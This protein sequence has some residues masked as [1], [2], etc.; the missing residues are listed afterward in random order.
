MSPIVSYPAFTLFSQG[1]SSNPMVGIRYKGIRDSLKSHKSR[2][3]RKRRDFID[4]KCRIIGLCTID[5]K[6]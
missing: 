3:M 2:L 6:L 5:R 4:L 1:A